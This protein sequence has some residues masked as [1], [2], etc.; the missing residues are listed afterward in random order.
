MSC[1]SYHAMGGIQWI[2]RLPPEQK[3][4][5]SSLAGITGK[6]CKGNESMNG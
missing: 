5:S 6:I 1:R 4:A 3:V 2:E